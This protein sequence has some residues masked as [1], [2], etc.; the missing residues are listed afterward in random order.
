M[1]IL[2]TDLILSLNRTI[3]IFNRFNL[4]NNEIQLQ[5][6]HFLAS[7]PMNPAIEGATLSFQIK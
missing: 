5:Q 1:I 7:L 3:I 2:Y 4:R 6:L